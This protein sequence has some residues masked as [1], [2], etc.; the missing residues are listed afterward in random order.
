MNIDKKLIR[1]CAKNDRKSQF[2]LY[3]ECYRLLMS[4]CYRYKKDKSE[5]EALMNMGFM[6]IL[7]KL[8][9]Y[10]EEG[11]FDAW[12][13]KIMINTI[14]DEYRKNKKGKEKIEYTDF[15]ESTHDQ[16]NVDY[17]EADKQFNAEELNLMLLKLPDMSRKVFNLY[18]V[19]GY[20]HKEIAE[21][22][23]I[24]VGTSKWHVSTARSE[25]KK[26]IEKK[27]NPVEL[28]N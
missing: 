24:S 15:Q 8:D 10:N 3:K 21:L 17:N 18:A 4:V 12:S 5:A 14:I 22:F 28:E 11:P 7:T 26:L 2:L 1:S 20:S 16:H 27:L 13:R 25:L 6:K 9:K 23:N 19:D